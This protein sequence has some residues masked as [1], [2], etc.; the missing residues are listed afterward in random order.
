VVIEIPARSRN[1]Y[2]Y[3]PS[4]G[5]FRLDRTL[6][7]PVEYPFEYGFFPSTLG[8]DGDALD[9]LLLTAEPTFPGCVV[10]V[11]PVA[12]LALKDQAGEDAKI[13]VVPAEDPRFAAV[14]D[15]KSVP[16]HTLREIEEFFRT[17]SVLEG[18]KKILKGWSGREA[19]LKEIRKAADRFSRGA[20]PS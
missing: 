20:S 11:R 9:V 7:S 18:K 15:L 14:R 17:Y 10:E 6:Y 4:L 3:D 1:K 19:A 8:G 5:I 12:R 2:E 16:P 13:L